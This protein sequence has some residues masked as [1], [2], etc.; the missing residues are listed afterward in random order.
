MQNAI[1]L[2]DHKIEAIQ[3]QIF[4]ALTPLIS[5]FLVLELPYLKFNI[6]EKILYSKLNEKK[7][8]NIR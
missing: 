3:S 4:D 2:F 1:K 8:K 7:M 5:I 6:N